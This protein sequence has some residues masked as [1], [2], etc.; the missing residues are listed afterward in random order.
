MHMQTPQQTQRQ[1]SQLSLALGSTFPA[2][3]WELRD[4]PRC[5]GTWQGRR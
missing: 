2:L 1:G 4:F 5:P 3:K